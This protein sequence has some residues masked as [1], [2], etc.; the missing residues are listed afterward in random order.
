MTDYNAWVKTFGE[1]LTNS[2]TKEPETNNTTESI[3]TLKSRY[4]AILDLITYEYSLIEEKYSDD[5]NAT[6]EKL[7]AAGVDLNTLSQTEHKKKLKVKV[8]LRSRNF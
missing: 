2:N 8:R 1:L 5:L 7:I 3:E 6:R 4:F